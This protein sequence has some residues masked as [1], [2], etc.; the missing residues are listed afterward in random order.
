MQSTTVMKM[1]MPLLCSPACNIWSYTEQTSRHPGQK[2]V[3]LL[4]PVMQS[5][6]GTRR[7]GSSGVLGLVSVQLQEIICDYTTQNGHVVN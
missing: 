7:T 1:T 4:D 2:L 6:T 5:N 3:I